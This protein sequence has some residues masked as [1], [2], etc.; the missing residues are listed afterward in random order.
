MF[1]LSGVW[2]WV[3]GGD[4]GGAECSLNNPQ[5]S[6]PLKI[7]R[8]R[9]SWPVLPLGSNNVLWLPESLRFP[10]DDL[11]WQASFICDGDRI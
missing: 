2:A 5:Q 6:Y 9:G 10:R 7:E 3:G 11:G 8:E 1:R 4:V